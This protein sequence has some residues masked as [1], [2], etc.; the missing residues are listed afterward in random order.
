MTCFDEGQM[1]PF[2]IQGQRHSEG[3]VYTKDIPV[4]CQ[5]NYQMIQR[6]SWLIVREILDG[7]TDGV[8]NCPEND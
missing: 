4:Y 3:V 2:P 6:C 7:S 8:R 1:A 5:A